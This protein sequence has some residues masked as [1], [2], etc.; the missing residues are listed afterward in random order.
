[1]NKASMRW[2]WVGYATAFLAGA[3]SLA[4][5]L[6]ADIPGGVACAVVIV[7]AILANA[8][9]LAYAMRCGLLKWPFD[10]HNQAWRVHTGAWL[11]VLLSLGLG[12]DPAGFQSMCVLLGGQSSTERALNKAATD[13]KAMQSKLLLQLART[14]EGPIEQEQRNEFKHQL[15]AD[16]QKN[17]PDIL[18]LLEHGNPTLQQDMLEVLETLTK[19]PLSSYQGRPLSSQDLQ[20]VRQ[21]VETALATGK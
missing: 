7:I 12:S 1:M 19:V 10:W 17:I 6:G 3:A 21:Q 16:G 18:W 13:L 9:T 8:I 5:W 11:S 4:R 15:V 2:I 14:Y 20:Q